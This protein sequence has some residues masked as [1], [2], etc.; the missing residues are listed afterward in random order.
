MQKPLAGSRETL[1]GGSSAASRSNF[2]GFRQ[3]SASKCNST[4]SYR[5]KRIGDSAHDLLQPSK[6]VQAHGC[7]PFYTREALCPLGTQ[8]YALHWLRPSVWYSARTWNWASPIQT[9]L[10]SHYGGQEMKEAGSWRDSLQP[11]MLSNEP[12]EHLLEQQPKPP[13]FHRNNLDP[14][15]KLPVSPS[16]MLF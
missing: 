9:P 6:V 16:R 7:F 14:S 2:L 5:V 3:L 12:A 13:C 4:D 8:K 1:V 11:L 15:S 10:S